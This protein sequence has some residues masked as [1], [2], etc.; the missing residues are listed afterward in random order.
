M[1]KLWAEDTAIP[2]QAKMGGMV[3]RS[4]Q[5][6]WQFDSLVSTQVTLPWDYTAKSIETPEVFKH[7][8]EWHVR[9]WLWNKR[10]FIVTGVTVAKGAKMAKSDTRTIGGHAAVQGDLSSAAVPVPANMDGEISVVSKKSDKARMEVTDFVISYSVNEVFF[11]KQTQ[12]PY[13]CGEVSSVGENAS[14]HEDDLCDNEIIGFTLS[15]VCEN[16]Y[17]GEGTG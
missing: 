9:Q 5:S 1:F 8:K 16:A 6:D 17:V 12:K 4:S 2:V 7:L 10:L 14:E 11:E 13:R 3:E 15:D